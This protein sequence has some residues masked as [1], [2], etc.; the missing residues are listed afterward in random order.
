MLASIIWLV[1]WCAVCAYMIARWNELSMAA[2]IG[3][4]I[5]EFVTVPD[6]GFLKSRGRAR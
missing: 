6:L 1:A 3:L 5:V 2:K 4:T